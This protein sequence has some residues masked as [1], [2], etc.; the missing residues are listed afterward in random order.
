MCDAAGSPTARSQARGA[1]H[2]SCGPRLEGTCA[3]APRCE[4]LPSAVRACRIA[5]TSRRASCS[6]WVAAGIAHLCSSLRT[7]GRLAFSEAISRELCWLPDAGRVAKPVRASLGVRKAQ[8]RCDDHGG[9][10][11][12]HYLLTYQSVDSTLGRRCLQEAN[13]IG[14]LFHAGEE[15]RAPVGVPTQAIACCAERKSVCS[16]LWAR[17]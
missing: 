16:G 11:A 17:Q 3:R 6:S 13:A 10:G 15:P 7:G 14:R 1:P 5:R 2:P 8:P 9:R 4:P 12:P